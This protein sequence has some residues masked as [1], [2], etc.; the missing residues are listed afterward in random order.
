VEIHNSHPF[1]KAFDY[2]SGATCERFQN[3]L[4]PVTEIFFGGEFK[5]AVAQ[6]KAFGSMIVSNAIQAK[7]SK[8]RETN[9]DSSSGDM[10]GSLINSL[11]E[12]IDDHQMVADAALN[13]LSAGKLEVSC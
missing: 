12:S 7:Q 3:P 13:Y 11:L 1:S 9:I 4:W 2:A 5:K 10:S 6:V 8:E